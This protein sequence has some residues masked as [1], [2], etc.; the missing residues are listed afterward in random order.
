MLPCLRKKC[1]RFIIKTLLKHH[2]NWECLSIRS[3]ILF[4]NCFSV[5]PSVCQKGSIGIFGIWRKLNSVV[6]L[7]MAICYSLLPL[8]QSFK[9]KRL[10]IE[11]ETS[12]AFPALSSAR[13]AE[14]VMCDDGACG[15][16]EQAPQGAVVRVGG[17]HGPH[18]TQL[19]HNWSFGEI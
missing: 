15:S 17:P 8:G 14:R 19:P 10:K 13:D 9:N 7:W 18:S 11:A 16:A 4:L 5:P 3:G 6:Q 12:K 1:H 2:K